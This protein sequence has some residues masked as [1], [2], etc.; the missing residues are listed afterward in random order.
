MGVWRVVSFFFS[1][2]VKSWQLFHTRIFR[3]ILWTEVGNLTAVFPSRN[4][5]RSLTSAL[6]WANPVPQAQLHGYTA[7]SQS[8]ASP[9]SV[10]LVWQV[11]TSCRAPIETLPRL[12]GLGEVYRKLL[13]SCS[14]AALCA[15]GL[16]CFIGGS[17]NNPGWN[18]DNIIVGVLLK[19]VFRSEN[20]LES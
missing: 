2:G 16:V 6:A 20:F 9:L 1:L 13:L 19:I 8:L 14:T 18:D 11:L 10:P 5:R 7:K 17:R 12:P 4:A 15:A 3:V